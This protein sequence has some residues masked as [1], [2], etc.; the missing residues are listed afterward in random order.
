ML[1]PIVVPTGRTPGDDHLVRTVPGTSRGP[2][3]RL[4]SLPPVSSRPTRLRRAGRWLGRQDLRLLRLAGSRPAPAVDAVLRSTSLAANKSRLWMATAALLGFAG[5]SRGRRAARRGML[6]IALTSSIVNG[7]L[8][9]LWRRERPEFLE[10]RPSLV[11]MPK[12]FSFPSGHSASA[13]AFATGVTAEWPAAGLPVTAAAAAVTYSRVHNGVHY[14]SD[15][16]VGGGLGVA[17]GLVAGRLLGDRV[18]IKLPPPE[19]ARIPRRAVLLT[20]SGAGPADRL[21]GARA[22]LTAAGIELLAE[23]AVDKAAQLREY[24]DRADADR[25]L[26]IAGGGDATIGAAVDEIGDSRAI[27]AILPLGRANEVARSLNI[28]ADPVQAAGAIA[29]G[30]VRVIDLGRLLVP[31]QRPRHFV[32]AATA[33]CTVR[34]ARL[35]TN[36]SVR[37]RFGRFGYAVATAW[38]TREHEPFECELRYDATSEQVRLAQ[39]SII[40]AP[41]F[42]GALDLR[43]P[44]ARVDDRSLVVIAVE[45]GHPIRLVLG[46]LVAG[47]GPRR[48]AAGVRAVRTNNLHVHVDRPLDVVLDGEIT[49]SL[50]ADFEVAAHALRVVTPRLRHDRV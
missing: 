35:A 48:S 17:A 31:D 10:S 11:T 22:A 26:I 2:Y 8:K 30:V 16:I 32:H 15:V 46:A 6:A 43:V 50:P 36:S 29:D 27:L 12:S 14:P 47:I 28:P 37:R 49:A 45:P 4:M 40:N 19:S 39:L 1:L 24:L 41:V 20:G 13:F 42:G 25:P 18:G 21:D 9:F 5:G 33:G 38:A 23:I 44:G 3:G 34:F 7:P